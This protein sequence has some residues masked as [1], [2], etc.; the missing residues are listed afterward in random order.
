LRSSSPSP[1][2]AFPAARSA[3]RCPPAI[4]KQVFVYTGLRPRQRILLSPREN[5]NMSSS[6]KVMKCVQ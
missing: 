6:Q 5:V 2:A 1:Y 4:F 3:R